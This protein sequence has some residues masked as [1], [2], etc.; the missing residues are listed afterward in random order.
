MIERIF[1]V[2]KGEGPKV[3]AFALLVALLQAGMAI[4][5][6][7]SDALFLV[8][9]GADKLP[10]IYV[11]APFLMLLFTP[12]FSYLISRLGISRVFD[13]TLV[14]LVG[15]GI[16]FQ[17]V[18]AGAAEAPVLY[19]VAKLYCGIW[20]IALFTLFWN[21]ADA[22]FDIQDAKRL[23]PIFNGG[24]STGAMI[25]G[26]AVSV[27]SGV[28]PVDRLF[29]VWAGLAIATAPV[30]FVLRRRFRKIETDDDE[31][32]GR[33][34]VEEL[35]QTGQYLR[36][37]VYVRLLT[38]VLF[39]ALVLTTIIEFQYSTIFAEGRSEE[40]LASLL[41][42]L[43]AGVNFF[44][45]LVNFF[46]F[47]RL[48]LAFGVGNIALA[49]PVVYL[50][51]YGLLLFN[52]GFG[53]AVFAFFSYQGILTAIDWNNTNF[54]FNGIPSEAKK[55][56]RTVIEGLC[57]PLATAT[58]GGFLL[59]FGTHVGYSFITRTP[60]KEEVSFLSP[61]GISLLGLAGAAV[62]LVMAAVLRN[63]YRTSMVRNLKKEWLDFSRP[64]ESLLSDL[65]TSD[66]DELGKTAREGDRAAAATAIRIL[67]MND[68]RAA[69]SAL[70]DR[71][72]DGSTDDRA[73]EEPLLEMMLE[74]EDH[75]VV[76]SLL[77]WWLDSQGRPPDPGLLQILASHGLVQSQDLAH[78]AGVTDPEARAATVVAAWNSSDLGDRQ[79]A[80]ESIASLLEGDVPERTAA[81]RALGRT[82]QEKNAHTVAA[83]LDDP[84]PAIR[85][86]AALAVCRLATRDSSRLV[87]QI[88]R[89]VARSSGEER[90]AGLETLARIADPNSIIPLLAEAEEFSPPERRAAEHA[91]LS[92]GLKGVPATV[93]VLRDSAAPYRVRSLAARALSRTAFPQ[94]EAISPVLIR[95]ELERA[96]A[97]LEARQ[98]LERAPQPGPG[99]RVLSRVYAD[100]PPAIVD[101][102]LEL[103]TL[104]GRLPD[105]ELIVASLRSGSRK[106]RA[107]AIETIEQGVER[108]IFRLLLPLVD[109]RPLEGQLAFHRSRGAEAAPSLGEILRRGLGSP[110]PLESAAAAQALCEE[111]KDAAAGALRERMRE[112]AAPVVRE[113][114]LSLLSG[115]DA[116]SE[117]NIV[118]KLAVL[119]GIPGFG[120]LSMRDLGF[121]ARRAEP[122]CFAPGAVVVSAGREARAVLATLSGEARAGDS[123]LGAGELLGTGLFCLDPSPVDVVAEGKLCALR[124]PVEAVR[125]AAR[126]HPRIA[127]VLFAERVRCRDAA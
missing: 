19:Y 95:S 121:L 91:I 29:L 107:N 32:E 16:V 114:I 62:Y 67:W 126:V 78:L 52:W 99:L 123:R 26:G 54:L 116:A 112:A 101:F 63:S 43:T 88:L 122:L 39:T 3:L 94:L 51:A 66:L 34:F 108:E 105:F 37:S 42:R 77:D 86:A 73:A 30:L 17:L 76:R 33:G 110:S 68:R 125:E 6:S 89:S 72:Q 13:V 22:Y 11:L 53:A 84:E 18:L 4:G 100:Q 40:E 2:R 80:L 74:S 59:L 5:M 102:V 70:L 20:Y 35:Q 98:V 57:E 50:A 9:I 124:I 48:V 38:L 10:V 49:T 90:L 75:E 8:N 106:D 85:R 79:E 93:S 83:F 12:A 81:L 31:D 115:H 69:L 92:V 1:K 45:L 21:F 23:F 15:G 104:G 113:T 87:P 55:Q 103:L 25:G 71:L 46:L 24:A 65:S 82:N 119:A 44:T 64:E 109:G 111:G 61:E 117:P 28:M 96:Y 36:R 118:E 41:G 27:L 60:S 7:A 127:F 14:A 120:D 97:Y 58:A 47:N 56:V